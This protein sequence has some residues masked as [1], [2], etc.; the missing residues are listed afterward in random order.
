MKSLKW[1][2]QRVGQRIF[3]DEDNCTCDTCKRNAK[4]GLIVNDEDHAEYLHMIQC[5]FAHCGTFLN[6]RDKK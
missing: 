2:K 4:E 6:Y 5:D 1:F 3:R